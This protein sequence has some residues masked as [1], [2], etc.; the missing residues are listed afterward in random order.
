MTTLS[1]SSFVLFGA[2]EGIAPLWLISVGVAAAFVVLAIA[3][4]LLAVAK[5]AA[6]RETLNIVRQGP[7]GPLTIAA[8]KD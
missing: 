6:A 5:P 3:Y 2:L 1:L 8:T 4:G 7:L